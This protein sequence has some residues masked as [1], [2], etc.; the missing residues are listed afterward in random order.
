[1]KKIW[2]ICFLLGSSLAIWAQPVEMVIDRKEAQ[3]GSNVC[4]S[5]KIRSAIPMSSIQFGI[6]W[7][8]DILEFTELRNDPIEN[9]PAYNVTKPGTMRLLHVPFNN[10]DSLHFQLCFNVIGK[11]SE[12]S[13]VEFINIPESEIESEIRKLS[14]E[15]VSD[16][17]TILDFTTEN[18]Y[19]FI[20]SSL[21]SP[22]IAKCIDDVVVSLPGEMTLD[23]IQ[24]NAGSYD[25]EST[26]ESLQFAITFLGEPYFDIS[27][28]NFGQQK[29]VI[30]NADN[31][32]FCSVLELHVWDEA[33]Q[34]SSCNVLIQVDDPRNRCK[35]IFCYTPLEIG[36]QKFETFQ[37]NAIDLIASN[38]FREIE[39]V[40]VS[41]NGG[42]ALSSFELSLKDEGTISYSVHD[43]FIGDTCYGEITVVAECLNATCINSISFDQIDIIEKDTFSMRLHFYFEDTIRRLNLPISWDPS[44]LQFLSV[45]VIGADININQDHAFDNG[46][47]TLEHRYPFFDPYYDDPEIFGDSVYV[48]FTFVAIGLPMDST[49]VRIANDFDQEYH[50]TNKYFDKIN[51]QRTSGV[52]RIIEDPNPPSLEPQKAASILI[53]PN[54][55]TDYISII[56]DDTDIGSTIE[57]YNI[58]G[59]LEYSKPI[60]VE[61]TKISL[62]LLPTS[63]IKYLYI[64]S[65]YKGKFIAL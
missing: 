48:D 40:F 33:Y 60:E 38:N 36:V 39:D 4:L 17:I 59:E 24:I 11:D 34:H 54:P 9:G 35:P 43:V 1:M 65:I 64:N 19:V 55:A 18:G 16:Q 31:S 14:I 50:V 47:L 5:A 13:G 15:I 10:F 28:T 26:M 52:V 61:N 12:Y 23:A 37:F 6:R 63:G 53:Y 27:D 2:F 25:A 44:I 29:Q 45:D 49:I 22:P 21:D 57:I 56:H 62:D 30:L 51:Y 7:D 32:C 42:E 3:P 8:S 58:L 46:V 41:I 20:G